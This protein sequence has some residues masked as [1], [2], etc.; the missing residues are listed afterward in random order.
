[1]A[2]TKV[3]M[4]LPDDLLTVVDAFVEEHPGRTRSSVCADALRGWL[5]ARQEEEIERYY[6]TLS[7]EAQSEEATWRSIAA[8]SAEQLWP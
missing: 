7:D 1:M 5:R 3:T 6:L 2:A 8:Q 4:T